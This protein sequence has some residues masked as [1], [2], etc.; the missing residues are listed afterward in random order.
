MPGQVI[1]TV[2]VQIGQSPNPRVNNIT[3]GGR[4]LK[5]ANDLNLAGAVDGD[6]IVYQANTNTFIVEPVSAVIP[7]LDLIDGGLF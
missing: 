7:H 3:Y 5:S 1:G 4:S 6:V 2:N